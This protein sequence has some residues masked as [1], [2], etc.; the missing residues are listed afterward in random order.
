MDSTLAIETGRDIAKPLHWK[1]RLLLVWAAAFM[2]TALQY[3]PVRA[4][5]SIGGVGDICPFRHLTGLPCPLCGMTRSV[6]CFFQGNWHASLLWHPLGPLV[7]ISMVMGFLTMVIPGIRINNLA[8]K[9]PQ[10]FCGIALVV[11]VAGC[12]ALRLAGV[13]PLPLSP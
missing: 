8:A 11:L 12:W 10:R 7:G 13:F 9:L 3:L 2:L 6:L 1:W 4:D 5:G